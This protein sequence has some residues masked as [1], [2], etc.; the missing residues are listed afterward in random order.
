MALANIDFNLRIEQMKKEQKFETYLETVT[1]FI[2]NESDSEPEQIAKLL[3]K[4]IKEEIY[5]ESINESKIKT[6]DS[7]IHIL[8]SYVWV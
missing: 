6:Q 7:G 8:Q 4:K 5:K 1:Y 2:E 3:N